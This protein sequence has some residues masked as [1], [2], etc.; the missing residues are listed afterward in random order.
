[1]SSSAE[2]DLIYKYT[3]TDPKPKLQATKVLQ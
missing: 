3:T 2:N 1:M